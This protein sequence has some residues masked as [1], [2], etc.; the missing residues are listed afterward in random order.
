MK[1]G[2]EPGRLPVWESPEGES[3]PV[4]ES[5]HLPKDWVFPGRG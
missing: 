4:G 3:G 5:G 1:R 2:G